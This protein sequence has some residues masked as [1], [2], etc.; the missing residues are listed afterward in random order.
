MANRTTKL[1]IILDAKTSAAVR[2]LAFAMGVDT[3]QLLHEL[4]RAGLVRAAE[5]D[6]TLCEAIQAGLLAAGANPKSTPALD[7]VVH[8]TDWPRK[9]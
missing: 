4:L 3:R 6:R 9:G 8:L 2:S 1:S 5:F 7:V